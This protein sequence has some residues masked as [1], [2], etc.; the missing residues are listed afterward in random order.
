VELHMFPGGYVG[1]CEI[2]AGQTNLCLLIETAIFRHVGRNHERLCQERLALNPLLR[3]R[4]A[5]LRPVWQEVVA[6]ANLTF[7]CHARS[8]GSVLMVGDAAASISPLCGNGMSM[9][10]RSGEML[11]PLVHRFL[12]GRLTAQALQQAYGQQWHHEFSRRLRLGGALQQLFLNPS[13]GQVAMMLLHRFPSLG[14]R[15][16]R[17]TRG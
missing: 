1:L 9:A 2:E 5:S 7:G 14:Q 17:W 3:Q 12:S 11:A 13:L 16:I 10:L 6:V 8:V 4:L 15:L